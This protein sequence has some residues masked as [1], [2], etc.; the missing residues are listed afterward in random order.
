MPDRAF[1]REWVTQARKVD[2]V[3]AAQL[4]L[5][6]P[7]FLQMKYLIFSALLGLGLAGCSS[8]TESTIST[9]PD[10]TAATTTQPAP[11]QSPEAPEPATPV[12]PSSADPGAMPSVAASPLLDTPRQARNVAYQGE[13]S[14]EVDNFEQATASLNQLLDQFGA[15][16]STAHET[17]AN[18]Q[19]Y[20][21]MT[22]KVPATEFL[23]LVAA[24]GKLGH[25]ASKDIGA[26]DI[27][28][29]LV[30]L[31][32]RITAQQATAAKYRQ[33]VAQATNPTQVRQLEDQSRQAQAALAA[34]K[35][36]LQQLGLGTQGLWATLRLRYTQ[37]G[38]AEPSTPLPAFAP[39]FA[40]S[41][42]NG[43][44]FVMSLLIA[45]T[46]VWPLLVLVLAAWSAFRW[47]RRQHPAEY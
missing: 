16:P 13:M 47:W 12:A 32:T 35:A 6:P 26:T 43:W 20:Q 11:G 27:T 37:V 3:P 22:L 25:T 4:I 17:R 38:V 31:S 7:I 14:L 33:L 23:H 15:F 45:L 21:E 24:L 19:H 30:A 40:A 29:D 28:A 41:F 5:S 34:D 46:N 2:K 36:R 18:G 42:N 39:Q 8:R 1:L 10:T 9:G 44:S